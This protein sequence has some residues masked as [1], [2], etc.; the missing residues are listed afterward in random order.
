MVHPE[1]GKAVSKD[2]RPAADALG[3]EVYS[4][5]GGHDADIAQRDVRSLSWGEDA[6]VGVQVQ[7]LSGRRGAAFALGQALDTGTGVGQDVRRPAEH[8]VEDERAHCDN[9]RVGR[10]VVNHLLEQRGLEF[11]GLDLRSARG[12]K[13]SVLLH[14]VVVAVVACVGELPAEEG[15]QQHAVEDPASDGVDGEIGRKRI[16]AAVVGE[17]PKTREEASLDE[18]VQEPERCLD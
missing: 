1:V 13:Y 4:G 9:G 18:A 2:G 3:C 6:G 12:H 8:L 14:V 7:L 10:V 17:D 5:H 16:M 15:N 11:G